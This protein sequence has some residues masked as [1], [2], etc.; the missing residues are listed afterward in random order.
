[1][2]QADHQATQPT[3]VIVVGGDVAAQV[4]LGTLVGGP[5]V[6]V[7][8]D[9]GLDRCRATGLAVHHLVGDL[10]S[11][12]PVAVAE[13]K[14]TATVVH[15]HQADKDATDLELAVDLVVSLAD[16]QG[17]ADPSVLVVGGG[18]GRIDHLLADLMLLAGPALAGLDVH[19]RFGDATVAVARPG[20]D[21]RLRG[22][23]CDHV[24]LLPVGGP[25]LGVETSGLRWPLVD[26]DLDVGTTR[27]MS[28]ELVGDTAT[29]AV[30]DGVLLVIQPGTAGPP[31]AS[32][33]TAYDPS[34]RLGT[35]SGP[36]GG[37]D[38]GAPTTT[39][40]KGPS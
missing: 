20:R 33:P 12:D 40:T 16:E 25:A 28:N 11:A 7:A 22:R 23:P 2:T 38:V 24:S 3:F 32:R 34:P 6:V 15:R 26:A 35:A 13:T 37:A 4:D 1:M 36:D 31:I 10:D 18:G 30:A 8:A 9:S 29:V 39:R 19:A 5:A 17:L 27:A 21:V 14:D